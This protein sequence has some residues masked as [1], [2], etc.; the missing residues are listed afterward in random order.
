VVSE[1]RVVVGDGS[2][3]LAEQGS[4]L[5]RLTSLYNRLAWNLSSCND[6]MMT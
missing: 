2:A 6:A 5:G 4:E 3:G 1:L